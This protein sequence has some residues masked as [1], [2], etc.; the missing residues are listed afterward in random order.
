MATIS[1][2]VPNAKVDY[3]L[4]GFCRATDYSGPDTQAAKVAHFRAY[5]I[6][7]A[8]RLAREGHVKDA[9]N[10]AAATTSATADAQLE[11]T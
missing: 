11:M 9:V 3:L 7:L 5:I 10:T 2:D 8:K 4:N 1:F 6:A